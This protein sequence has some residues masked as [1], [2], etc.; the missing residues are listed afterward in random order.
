MLSTPVAYPVLDA[1]EA[2]FRIKDNELFY[3]PLVIGLCMS[4]CTSRP[5]PPKNRMNELRAIVPYVLE[6][7]AIY[8]A[9]KLEY[10]T[11]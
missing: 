9:Q 8:R 3:I 6:R 1:G 10:W 2:E 4:A 11:D 7:V 5:P